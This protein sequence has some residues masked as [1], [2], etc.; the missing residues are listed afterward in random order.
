MEAGRDCGRAGVEMN[1][2]QKWERRGFVAAGV[3]TVYVYRLCRLARPVLFKALFW[4][5]VVMFSALMGL[6][7]FIGVGL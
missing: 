1:S 4:L 2:K 3:L 5:A 7:F 6:W